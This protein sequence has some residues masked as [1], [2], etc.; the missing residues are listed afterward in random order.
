MSNVIDNRQYVNEI[1]Q[2]CQN[3]SIAIEKTIIYI[4][5]IKKLK[6]KI[7]FI[8]NGASNTIGSHFALDFSKN[9]MIPSFS[10]NNSAIITA[11]ANDLDPKLIFSKYLQLISSKKDLLIAISSSGE[12]INII[13]AVNFFKKIGSVITLTGMSATNSLIKSNKNGVN[14]HVNLKGY[15][16]IE[17]AHNVIL[18]LITDKIK[19]RKIY[20]VNI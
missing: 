10:L 19:G 13:K 16:Q 4:K 9:L 14:I 6:R 12:S 8:G 3:K 11:I 7:F 5:K 17:S 15:N 1:F 18:G 2:E 20:S